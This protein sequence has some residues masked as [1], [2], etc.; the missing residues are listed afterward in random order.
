MKVGKCF[1]NEPKLLVEYLSGDTTDSWLVCST[2]IKEDLFQKYI[3]EK[4]D[5]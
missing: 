1:E 4:N 3:K 2:C 5:L